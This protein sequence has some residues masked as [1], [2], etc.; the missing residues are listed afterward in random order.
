MGGKPDPMVTIFLRPGNLKAVKTKV[1][2]NE[3]NPT[4]NETFRF[5]VLIK[6]RRKKQ[7]FCSIFTISDPTSR[8]CSE[9]SD[10]A[11]CRLGQIFQKWPHGRGKPYV[12]TFVI[13][14]SI[15]VKI[16]LSQV[17]VLRGVSKMSILQQVTEKGSSSDEEKR[18]NGP[19]VNSGESLI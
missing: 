17:D 9:N 1:M 19:L 3:Q 2:K 16:A 11:G 10:H 7:S 15:K 6:W 4:F 5:Q 8:S 14:K 12:S 13:E 18:G